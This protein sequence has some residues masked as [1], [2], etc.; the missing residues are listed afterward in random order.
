VQESYLHWPVKSVIPLG[1]LEIKVI[2]SCEINTLRGIVPR[3]MSVAEKGVKGKELKV[4]VM[5]V[6]GSP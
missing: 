6:L 2:V 1:I 5:D 3:Y 4:P